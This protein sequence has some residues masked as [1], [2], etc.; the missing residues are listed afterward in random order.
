MRNSPP[1]PPTH[2]TTIRSSEKILSFTAGVGLLGYG[3]KLCYEW[4]QETYGEGGEGEEENRL[5]CAVDK[6]PLLLF[7]I[8]TWPVDDFV[9]TIIIMTSTHNLNVTPHN[10]HPIRLIDDIEKPAFGSAEVHHIDHD[11]DHPS[12]SKRTAS[13]LFI[14]AFLGSLDDLTLFVPMLVG[15]ALSWQELSK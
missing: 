11:H 4:Y 14:V 3:G 9:T 5:V 6:G 13:A 15:E 10:H 2:T 12:K 8:S 7:L 1:P